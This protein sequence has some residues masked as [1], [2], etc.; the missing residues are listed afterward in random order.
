MLELCTAGELEDIKI[1]VLNTSFDHR[2]KQLLLHTQTD[3]SQREAIVDEQ[4]SWC[5]YW[6]MT[7]CTLGRQSQSPTIFHW[8][9]DIGLFAFL[10]VLTVCLSMH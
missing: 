3:R 9:P 6:K 8:I 5:N 1:R 2:N 7:Q 10:Y 4:Y